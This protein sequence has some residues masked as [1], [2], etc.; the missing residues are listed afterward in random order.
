MSPAEVFEPARR[1]GLAWFVFA[2]LAVVVAGVLLLTD[3]DASDSKNPE[4]CGAV[5]VTGERGGGD[6]DDIANSGQ[7][8]LRRAD[9]GS[10]A[11][12]V[13][14]VGVFL[15]AAGV[16]DRRYEP[17]RT[18]V[19]LG[20]FLIAVVLL[21][22]PQT[23]DHESGGDAQCGAPLLRGSDEILE[24]EE[25]DKVAECGVDRSKRLSWALVWS[26]VGTLVLV[27]RRPPEER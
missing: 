24:L 27:S 21:L 12:T 18:L 22:W 20:L 5:F 1:R 7:C 25:H 11:L 8:E 13:A 16:R 2:G 4:S 10:M 15:L 19:S 17:D 6:E 9:R 23:V 26:V 3:V 14:V